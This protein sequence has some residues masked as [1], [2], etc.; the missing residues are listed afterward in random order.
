MITHLCVTIS[1]HVFLFQSYE[2]ECGRDSN[3]IM[4]IHISD[5]TN[6]MSENKRKTRDTNTSWVRTKNKNKKKE[7]ENPKH[8]NTRR[9]IHTLFS[10]MVIAMGHHRQ[11]HRRSRRLLH[12]HHC[13]K[14]WTK[15]MWT[16]Q[17]QVKLMDV[18]YLRTA[19]TQRN[20]QNMHTYF[21][22][23]AYTLQVCGGLGMWHVL[24][25]IEKSIDGI[26]KRYASIACRAMRIRHYVPRRWFRISGLSRFGLFDGISKW[27]AADSGWEPIAALEPLVTTE[28]NAA[29]PPPLML[30][31][32]D[33]IADV[34]CFKFCFESDDVIVWPIFSE[35]A[36]VWEFCV[37]VKIEN[38]NEML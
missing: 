20:R 30:P 11:V 33:G 25:Q 26:F 1:L 14:C 9:Q 32:L 15:T 36:S 27:F 6:T 34:D 24:T 23:L 2:C 37:V 18:C 12:L 38:K 7:T 29:F 31:P 35:A 22:S 17:A 13:P 10:R 4:W 8:K 3:V 28:V 19:Q 5:Y 21:P 16:C